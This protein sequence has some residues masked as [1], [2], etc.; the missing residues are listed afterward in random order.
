MG[1]TVHHRLIR[2]TTTL[3]RITSGKFCERYF[4]FM[5]YQ[6][7]AYNHALLFLYLFIR[8]FRRSYVFFVS[9]LVCAHILLIRQTTT[10]CKITSK[11]DISKFFSQSY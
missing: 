2:K 6:R 10:Q 9:S 1:E 11:K 4:H 8:Y 7:K 5:C 3:Y